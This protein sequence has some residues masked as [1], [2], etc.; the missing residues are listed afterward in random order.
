MPLRK[1]KSKDVLSYNVGELMRSP[2]FAAGK[3][4]KKKQSMAVAASY[5]QARE[6]GAT[7]PRK[8]NPKKKKLFPRI[9]SAIQ[10]KRKHKK[11]LEE[12]L[13]Y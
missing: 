10:A 5:S 4:K 3:S 11:Q 1:G 8:R 2:T 13:E 9:E 12:A 7:L 6:S